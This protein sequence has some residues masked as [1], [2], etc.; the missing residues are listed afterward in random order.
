MALLSYLFHL[1]GNQNLEKLKFFAQGPMA[2][3][4]KCYFYNYYQ[5]TFIVWSKA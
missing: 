5:L 2:S 4:Q 1:W 3:E